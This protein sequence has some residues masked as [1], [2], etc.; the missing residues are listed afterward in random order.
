MSSAHPAPTLGTVRALVDAQAA[1]R[2]QALY[3]LAVDAE[4]AEPGASIAFGPLA[5]QCQQV[6]TLFAQ[7]G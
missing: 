2:A 1:A 3:A 4:P 6:A 7:H 5:Q